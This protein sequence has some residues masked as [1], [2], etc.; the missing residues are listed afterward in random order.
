MLGLIAG[1]MVKL[2]EELEDLEV[3]KKKK[4]KSKEIEILVKPKVME[5]ATA[6]FCAS[7]VSI[8]RGKVLGDVLTQ[9][10]CSSLKLRCA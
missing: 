9:C 8:L 3:L 10:R 4:Q 2:L 7:L 1:L 5:L 6:H